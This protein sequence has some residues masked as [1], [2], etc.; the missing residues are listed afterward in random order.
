MIFN[1]KEITRHDSDSE[2]LE[3][4]IQIKTDLHGDPLAQLKEWDSQPSKYR[5][6]GMAETVQYLASL[7]LN[8]KEP[9]QLSTFQIDL[10]FRSILDL[11][12]HLQKN[13]P[14]GVYDYNYGNLH[15]VARNIT[16]Q[17]T[18]LQ[19]KEKGHE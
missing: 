17:I 15:D 10:L 4:S 16:K 8:V 11:S 9:V 6:L 12:R 19:N 18:E 13:L 1:K 2:Y 14:D 7:S 5:I 3:R